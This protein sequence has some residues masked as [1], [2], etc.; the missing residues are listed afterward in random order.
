MSRLTTVPA[1]LAGRQEKREHTCQIGSHP[2]SP[3]LYNQLGAETSYVRNIA[4]GEQAARL[5]L[6]AMDAGLE[7][8]T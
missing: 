8:A 6:R 5:A 2:G 7:S 1:S 4:K 3:G